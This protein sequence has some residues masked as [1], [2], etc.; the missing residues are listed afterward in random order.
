VRLIYVAPPGCP[1]EITFRSQLQAR[2]ARLAFDPDA[3]DELRIVIERADHG[4][5]GHVV[6]GEP[7]ADATA[8]QAE[9]C[10]EVVAGLALSV[11][12]RVD[13]EARAVPDLPRAE[14]RERAP[15][16]PVSARGLELALLG[17]ASSG[18]GRSVSPQLGMSAGWVSFTAG[19]L[20][21]LPDVR[22]YLASVR[23]GTLSKPGLSAELDSYSAA[24]EACPLALAR[25]PVLSLCGFLEGGVVVATLTPETSVASAVLGLGPSVRLAFETRG[26]VA[27][28]RVAASFDALRTSYLFRPDSVAYRSP[29][30]RLESTLFIGYA[31]H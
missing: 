27:G 6:W 3:S 16:K 18:L 29:L 30:A 31:W 15:S 10:D 26:F 28:A 17:G 12:L 22:I 9:T 14:K 19:W 11:A 13:T 4:Y 7:P 2:T 8:L 24:L 1:G 25:Q 5:S 20:R 21:A 23:G